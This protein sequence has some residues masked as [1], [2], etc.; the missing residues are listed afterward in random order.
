MSDRDKRLHEA[1]ELAKD[2]IKEYTFEK[3][4]KLM[5]LCGDDI[6]YSDGGNNDFYIEDDHFIYENT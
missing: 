1:Y 2:M 6:F 3:Y 4:C 5:E